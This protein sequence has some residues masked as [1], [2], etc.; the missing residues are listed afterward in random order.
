MHVMA[1]THL[2]MQP[3]SVS[4]INML[5]RTFFLSFFFQILLVIKT[6]GGKQTE[7]IEL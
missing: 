5:R 1:T 2:C 4:N 6:F 7:Q 3:G